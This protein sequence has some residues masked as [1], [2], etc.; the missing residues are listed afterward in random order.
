MF[1]SSYLISLVAASF[2]MRSPSSQLPELYAPVVGPWIAIPNI[3]AIDKRPKKNDPE[4][5]SYDLLKPIGLG[6]LGVA[7]GVGALCVVGY[8]I[9]RPS[10]PKLAS[11]SVRVAPYVG[12]TGAGLVGSF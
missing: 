7:Q 12:L 3:I 6:L 10:P 2:S 11:S 1:G 5:G 9:D 4:E 8:L